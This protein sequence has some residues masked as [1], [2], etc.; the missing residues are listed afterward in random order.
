MYRFEYKC[1][2]P[3]Y[4]L[5]KYDIDY[6]KG[7]EL[8]REDIVFTILKAHHERHIKSGDYYTYDEA[9]K[10]INGMEGKQ[11]RTQEQVLEVLGFIEAAGSIPNALQA[12]RN[13]AV[14]V[15]ERLRGQTANV[16]MKY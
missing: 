1:K 13:D 8:F 9:A 15:P 10:R 4:L 7:F 5:K 3:R 16:V 6:N 2:N 12:I 11:Q 14:S